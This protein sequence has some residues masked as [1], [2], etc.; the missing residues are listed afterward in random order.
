MYATTARLPSGL[1]SMLSTPHGL[2]YVSLFWQQVVGVHDV[3][4]QTFTEPS[5]WPVSTKRPSRLNS[6]T[7]ASVPA[8]SFL[9]TLPVETSHT[10]TDP[11][12][13][14]VTTVFPFG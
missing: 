2:P 13:L 4:S 11:S 3:V 14:P 6:P 9:T 8:S 7:A 10:H 12:A 1:T 5:A